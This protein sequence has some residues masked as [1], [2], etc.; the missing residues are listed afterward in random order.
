MSLLRLH[1]RPSDL[2]FITSLANLVSGHF[3]RTFTAM[4]T[5]L[6]ARRPDILA[7]KGVPVQHLVTE[8]NAFSLLRPRFF[9]GLGI[10]TPAEHG[11]KIFP[12]PRRHNYGEYLCLESNS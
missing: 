6:A 4:A 10:Y 11:G 1:P 3:S 5:A 2:L 9:R 12:P 7:P 8:K